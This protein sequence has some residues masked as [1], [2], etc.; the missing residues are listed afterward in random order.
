VDWQWT[1]V[2]WVGMGVVHTPGFVLESADGVA[3]DVDTVTGVSSALGGA[4]VF[5]GDTWGGG[6]TLEAWRLLP[7]EVGAPDSYVTRQGNATVGAVAAVRPGRWFVSMG[8]CVGFG[9]MDAVS[10]DSEPELVEQ[11]DSAVLSLPVGSVE[12]T[13]RR[14]GAELRVGWGDEG[15]WGLGP[16][17]GVQVL[18]GNTTTTVNA[19]LSAAWQGGRS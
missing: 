16:M 7:K 1:P 11:G 12:G 13:L 17:L 4:V 3:L 18:R 6:L 10:A 8:P 9:R 15:M 19:V 14:A 2:A 5:G